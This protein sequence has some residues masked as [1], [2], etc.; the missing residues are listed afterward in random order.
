MSTLDI[1]HNGY[2]SLM[3]LGKYL[4]IFF[5]H[6]IYLKRI[7]STFNKRY[8]ILKEKLASSNS[9]NITIILF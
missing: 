9:I 7:E 5:R 6:V 1:F 3:P 4:F 2:C 8:V